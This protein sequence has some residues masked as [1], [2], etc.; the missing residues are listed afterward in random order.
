MTVK[1]CYEQLGGCYE[2]V[3]ERLM[4][5]ALVEKFLLKFLDDQTMNR[6]KVAVEAKDIEES[7]HQ[8]HTLK[9]IAANLALTKLQN[10]AS[11]LT[12]QLRTR[13][14]PADPVLFQELCI[15]YQHSIEVIRQLG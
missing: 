6:L 2:E 7:F 15:Q 3:L 11:E 9:G 8:A 5:D 10:A 13:T 1:E 12:E 4:K 14:N